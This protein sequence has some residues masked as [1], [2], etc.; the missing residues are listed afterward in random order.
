MAQLWFWRSPKNEHSPNEFWGCGTLLLWRLTVKPTK[1][2]TD[3]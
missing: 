2:E 1:T 3:L